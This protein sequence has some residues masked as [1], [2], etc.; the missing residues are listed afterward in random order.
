MGPG[1]AIEELTP[2]RR[3]AISYQRREFVGVIQIAKVE[4]VGNGFVVDFGEEERR[5]AT[6]ALMLAEVFEAWPEREERFEPTSAGLAA[7]EASGSVVRGSDLPQVDGLPWVDTAVDPQEW[8]SEP[9][10][11][12]AVPAASREEVAAADEV[13]RAPIAD[14]GYEYPPVR[15]EGPN[16]FVI[17]CPN[18]G[19][20][21]M[22]RNG[23]DWVC[24]GKTN[25]QACGVAI[26]STQ[27]RRALRRAA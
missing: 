10:A 27:M 16:H 13:T 6:D 21:R 23:A 26:P 2:R 18:H 15:Q 12:T 17:N 3:R 20:Q 9:T 11:P 1:L 19:E 14:D 5:V 8:P 25:K 24:A 22:T 4:K 7:L